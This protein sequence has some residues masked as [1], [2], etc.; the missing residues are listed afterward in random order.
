MTPG[1]IICVIVRVAHI[2]SPADC[3][4]NLRKYDPIIITQTLHKYRMVA[5]NCRRLAISEV[6][7][8]FNSAMNLNLNI[9]TNLQI[10]Q[11][12]YKI[13]RKIV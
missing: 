6:V 7:Y 9:F 4:Y 10:I 8:Y 2:R 1:G 3:M 13:G 11:L 5:H 12:L